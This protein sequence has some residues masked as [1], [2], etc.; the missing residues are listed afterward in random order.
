[1][2][3]DRE[4]VVEIRR[5]HFGEHWKRGTIATQLG[6]HLDVVTRVLGPRG[7]E[8]KHGAP[9]PS[10]L[11]PY[12][13]FL[14]ETLERYPRLCATRLYDMIVQR[15]YTGSLRTLRRFVGRHRPRVAREVFTR[16]E[17]LPG[18]QSQIAMD[19]LS[20][21]RFSTYA[22]SR[23][24]SVAFGRS[25]GSSRPPGSRPTRRSRRWTRRDGRPRSSDRSRLSARATSS[26][27]RRTCSFSGCPAA[28][29]PTSAPR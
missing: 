29:R 23:S 16:L 20:A 10:L 19:G 2:T 14:L 13:G 25:S 17:T 27:A 1:M 3:V 22:S 8:P 5:L 26:T 12:Q 18:E 21:S 6:V 4:T 7:P 11:D 28:G 15:G 24:K 9:R